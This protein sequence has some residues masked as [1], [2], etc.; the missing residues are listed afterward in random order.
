MNLFDA[1][2]SLLTAAMRGSSARSTALT[3]NLA[4]ADTPGYVP[5]DVDFHA[6]LRSALDASSPDGATERLDGMSF[7]AQSR[8]SG[9]M[10]ADGNGV[11]TD[12]ESA[13]LA[14]NGLEY[15]ALASIAR[16]RLEIVRIA[17]GA[18]S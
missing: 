18:A 11:D 15:Q 9:A 2:E 8:G 1:T 7:S 3:S 12:I 4:N 17:M 6:A 5:K 16:T 10:A 13:N 14:E